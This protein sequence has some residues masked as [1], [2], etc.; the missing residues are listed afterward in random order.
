MIEIELTQGYTAIVDDEDGDLTEF[1]WC[2]KASTD[3]KYVYAFRRVRRKGVFLHRVILARKL[4]RAIP[5]SMETDHED[6]NTLNN[7]RGNLRLATHGQNHANG[8]ERPRASRFRGVYRHNKKWQ[9]MISNP[10][11]RGMK[12]LGTF[13]TADDAAREYNRAA[14]ERWGEFA[15]LNEVPQ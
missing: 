11:G 10:L 2:A 15:R 6:W 14:L 12:P 5:K 3:G 4:G 9:A 7:R 1:K 8:R 13:P